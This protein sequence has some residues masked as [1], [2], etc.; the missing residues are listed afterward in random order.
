MAMLETKCRCPS[1]GV[2]LQVRLGGEWE[3]GPRMQ[4]VTE[5]V[6]EARDDLGSMD[7]GAGRA[8]GRRGRG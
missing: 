8:R 5:A 2:I 4:E 6:K 1:C 3:P 7:G